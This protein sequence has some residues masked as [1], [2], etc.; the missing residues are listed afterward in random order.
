MHVAAVLVLLSQKCVPS[1]FPP[2]CL[3]QYGELRLYAL[4]VQPSTWHG[5]FAPCLVQTPRALA[6][7][8]QPAVVQTFDLPPPCLAHVPFATDTAAVVQ[9]PKEQN[10]KAPCFGQSP[11]ALAAAPHSAVAQ[12]FLPP[13]LLQTPR[14]AASLL[15]PSAEQTTLSECFLHTPFPVLALVVHPDTVQVP[16]APCLAQ[17]WEPA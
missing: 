12:T 9:P 17:T 6:N 10:P 2:P 5:P 1:H 15:Q 4:V 14:A 3:W 13:C 8:V 11:R 16:C 7:V